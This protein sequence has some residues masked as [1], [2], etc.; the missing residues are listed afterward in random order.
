VLRRASI[1]DAG[2][3]LLSVSGTS[4][5]ERYRR[6]YYRDIQ[7]I[8][9]QKGPRL[10][11]IGAMLLTL[12][13]SI[14]FF[15]MGHLAWLIPMLWLGWL[16]YA[17]LARSCRVFIYTAVSS[18]ELPAVYR[19]R[20]AAR[21][22]PRILNKISEAQ[23]EFSLAQAAD[24]T[25]PVTADMAAIE[26][27]AVPV[28][29]QILYSVILF[30]LLF[31]G[32]AAFAYWYRDAALTPSSL[33]FGKFALP[34]LN[35]LEVAAGVWGLFKLAGN[36][37]MNSLRICIFAGLGVLALR[38]YAL[39]L[40]ASLM[41]Q[42]NGVLNDAI[43]NVRLRYWIGTVDCGLSIVVALAGLISLILAWQDDRQVPV[44]NL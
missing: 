14:P 39:L 36:R 9:V 24:L 4:F 40:V 10:G 5:S 29:R 42:R 15:F 19:R 27:A 44:S 20:S 35:A 41:S 43:S 18:E 1:W 37:L 25:R 33:L 38:T 32:S 7:A 22:L 13:F 6:F 26:T 23:G 31:I 11:S 2:E 30:S 21:V 28:S 34:I 12:W 3:Y 17:N 8:V 16:I